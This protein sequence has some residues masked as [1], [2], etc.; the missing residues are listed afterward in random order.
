MWSIGERIRFVTEYGKQL[1]KRQ[2]S[3]VDGARREPICQ[4]LDE[5]ARFLPQM[6]RSGDVD[7]AKCLGVWSALVEEGR[8]LGIGVVLLTQRS[9]R[10]NKD[11]AELADLMLAFRTVG[12]NSI[13]AVMDWL[14]AHLAKDR[15][16][17]M[18]EAVRS[19]PVGSCLAVSPGWLGVEKVIAVR[20]RETFDSSATPKPGDRGTRVK[21]AGAKP[22]LGVYAARMK[23]TIERAIAEDPR[24]LKRRIAELEAAA[25]KQP[26]ADRLVQ[27]VVL[28]P[29]PAVAADNARLHREMK[30]LRAVIGKIRE[31][32]DLPK[33]EDQAEQVRVEPARVETPRARPATAAVDPAPTGDGQPLRGTSLR[34]A[35]V[36]AAYALRG[37]IMRRSLLAAI[38]GQTDGGSFGNRIS[39]ARVAGA[40]TDVSPGVLAA[41]PE[42]MTKYGGTFKVP[43]T[44]EEV[45]ELWRPKLPGVSYRI[46]EHLVT[47]GG[48]PI[49]RVELAAA[50]GAVDG[51]TFGNR[52]SDVRTKGL[53][54]DTG[55]GMVA[56]NT[57]AL[58]MEASHA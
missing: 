51:G 13:D 46:L 15:L 57:E 14:S 20:L 35:Q 49:S 21:G 44:T 23:E 28:K 58:L 54:V 19:L 17:T 16:N 47:L 34:I 32:A 18:R 22:D 30:T 52:I 43:E 41:T 42:G 50:V 33:T 27:K 31:L 24:Q 45:M 3:L 40:I 56:A 12:P 37:K 2:G 53:L 11:V 1:F 39:E 5:A 26:V 10:L 38:L 55:R 4:V 6:I 25:Q 48:A 8:N 29:D 9:A 36:L 7:V